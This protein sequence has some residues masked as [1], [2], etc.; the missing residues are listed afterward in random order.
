MKPGER[1]GSVILETDEEFYVADFAASELEREG[2]DLEF[3][4]E[5]WDPPLEI[6]AHESALIIKGL[7]IVLAREGLANDVKGS[8]QQMLSDFETIKARQT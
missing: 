5:T 6:N 4:L 8:A 3:K 2:W 1:A 7:G